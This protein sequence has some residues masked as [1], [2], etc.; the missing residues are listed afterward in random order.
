MIPTSRRD[1]L[2]YTPSRFDRAIAAAALDAAEAAL[3]GAADAERAKA[4]RRV[5]S[6]RRRLDQVEANIAACPGGQPPVYW[7]EP[8]G[9]YEKTRALGLIAKRGAAHYPGDRDLVTAMRRVVEDAVDARIDASAVLDFLDRWDGMLAAGE[10]ITGA[11]KHQVDD[12]MLYFQ[13]HPLV[14]ARLEARAVWVAV[15]PIVAT[16]MFLVRAENVPFEVKR[17]RDGLIDERALA[18]IPDE[19]RNEIGWQAW[20]LGTLSEVDAKKSVPPSSSPASLPASTSTST[21][22]ASDGTS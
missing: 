21:T 10:V 11:D 19:D 13:A 16:Q 7:I 14:S 1:L 18:L 5:A 15:V 6:A 8:P 3:A 17:N 2:A 4:E 9:V 12:L 20:A 22:A